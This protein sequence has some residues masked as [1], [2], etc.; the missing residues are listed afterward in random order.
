MNGNDSGATWFSVA[1]LIAFWCSAWGWGRSVGRFF[2]VP[3]LRL[4]SIS[5]VVGLA[6][7]NVLGG[8]L[9][10]AR[11]ATAP[12]LATIMAVGLVFLAI[13]LTQSFRRSRRLRSLRQPQN[14]ADEKPV[15]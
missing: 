3:L 14:V 13:D 12:V 6:A 1:L 8:W 4:N 9:N 10:V 7:L 15:A 2:P 5:I 11:L